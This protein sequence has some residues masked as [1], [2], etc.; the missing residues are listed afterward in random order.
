MRFS[1]ALLW[2]G[3]LAGPLY[4]V[5]GLS[6]ALLRPGFD[7]TKYPLSLLSNGD[8]G[9]VQIANF[10]VTGLLVVAAALGWSR[11]RAGS[12]HRAAPWLLGVY[13]AALI[14]SGIFVADPVPGFPVGAVVPASM[15]PW[16]FVAGA[17][18]FFA[19]GGACFTASRRFSRQGLHGWSHFSWLTGGLFL[20]S[21]M[22]LASG[23]GNPWTL[24]AFWLGLTLTWV[25][26]GAVS[27]R[28]RTA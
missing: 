8:W 6:H 19:L 23:G 25:W 17:L 2:C 7:L 12:E 24:L 4:L 9:W 10:V 15:S 22:T 16:H 18:G 11:S 3:V 28:L 13:G 26:L 27:W 21:F 5:V 14:A 1:K 20:L